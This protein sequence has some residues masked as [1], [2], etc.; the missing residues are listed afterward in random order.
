MTR[1]IE[2]L[3]RREPS[4]Q[5]QERFAR[6]LS[7]LEQSAAMPRVPNRDHGNDVD[8]IEKTTLE[9]LVTSGHVRHVEL[10]VLKPRRKSRTSILDNADF[11]TWMAPAMSCQKTGELRLDHGRSGTDPD[12]A[13]VPAL[14][15]PRSVA[16]GVGFC[17]DLAPAPKQ[18]FTFRR[19]PDAATDTVEQEHSQ[20]GFQDLDLSRS[21]GLAQVEPYRCS[22][23]TAGIGNGEEGAQLMK[24]HAYN[25]SASKSRR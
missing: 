12:L 21:S 23:D 6:Q 15:C 7:D 5:Q 2:P 13:G 16:E 24:V 22:G 4:T 18:V 14:Q 11:H 19:Q 17:H 1:R 25:P 9:P 8:R 3:A 20:F 10:A